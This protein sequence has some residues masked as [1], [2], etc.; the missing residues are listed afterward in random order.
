M[1]VGHIK[2]LVRHP[3]KSFFGESVQETQ[4]MDYGLY[5]DRSHAFLDETRKN[6]FLTITQFPEM[7]RYK[8]RFSGKGSWTAIRM[9][10]S[11]HRRAG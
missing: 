11:L 10:R 6:K 8:A 4:I 7:V 1:L 5:G 3:V 9:S 2:E